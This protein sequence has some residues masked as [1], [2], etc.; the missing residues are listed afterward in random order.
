[1][2]DSDF[3]Q[4]GEL[5]K[6][7]GLKETLTI[8]IGTM[9]GAGI[10]VLPRFAIA[11]AG[12]GAVLAY[13]L[14]GV[15]CMITAAST[16]EL[17]TGMPKSGGAYFFVSRTMGAL[18]G[19]LSGVS[20]WLS[21]VFAVAF[22]LQGFGE[23][24]AMFL[25]L[26]PTILAVLAGAFFTYVNYIGAKETGK[27][28]NII[29]G[30]LLVI[31]TGYIIGGTIYFEVDILTPFL[32]EG[33]GAI[34][35][36]TALIFVSFLGFVQI[37]SVAE[38]VKDPD[39]T[40]PR[41]IIGSVAIVTMIYALVLLVTTGVIP[42]GELV[43]LDAP[44]V[45]VARVFGGAIGAGV[46]TFAALLATAS[47]ANA[48]ILASS[49]ISFALG[50]DAILPKYLNKVHP[51]FM[52]PYRPILLTGI[53]TV[54][55]ILLV[56]VAA[57]S[58]SASVLML[59]NYG[60]INLGVI[61]MRL[62]PPEG[63]EPSYK[64]PGYPVLHIIG[65]VSSFGVIFM[66]GSFAQIVA[67]VL[68]ILS[69]AWY[70]LWAKKRATV[71]GA[72]KNLEWKK[73]FTLKPQL[74]W[75]A[76]EEE[77]VVS[78]TEQ[79]IE[80]NI[81]R[82]LTPLA[83]PKHEKSMLE[84]STKLVQNIGQ[85]SEI[86][87]LNIV[88]IPE[89]TPLDF[90]SEDKDLLH[91]RRKNQQDMLKLAVEFG[92]KKGIIINP[93]VYYSRDKFKTIQNTIKTQDINFLLLGWYGSISAANIYNSF[94]KKLVR[95][96]ECPVGVLKG[97]VAEGSTRRILVPYRGSEHAYYGVEIA[98]RLASNYEDGK[99]SIL[100]IINDSDNIEEEREKA[101]EDIKGLVTPEANL[102]I[103]VI[104]EDKVVDGILAESSKEEYDLMILGAS[105][106]WRVKDM[107][108]GSIP[109]I[110]AERSSIPVLMVRWYNEKIKQIGE[111]VELEET[112]DKE[113]NKF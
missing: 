21:L 79:E 17:A 74:D 81:Y 22:Y 7:L 35:P 101:K 39:Y 45:E 47:S 54:L 27:T 82:V 91:E 31:L 90:I 1:M 32:P 55:L 56:D 73:V 58:D 108:F 18:T 12:P 30:I 109:D 5:V 94:V 46:I 105:K 77:P 72:I 71:T 2:A 89:Q 65:A 34:L 83:N 98:K 111:E 104:V 20:V 57:L 13:I 76:E 8:G 93:Q 24:L 68:V 15:M 92:E 84:L 70:L 62:S 33:P 100:R 85:E 26:N 113:P 40:L 50:K 44:I 49:R 86:N 67:L 38:E 9:I 29:V 52:T 88:E 37:A 6:E 14:A 53:L 43:E 41:S 11:E 96:A 3:S 80:E 28:Q 110:V 107:L 59:L 99:V 51:K 42:Y 66:A 60:L 61:I 36:T 106:K 103:K 63:Y 16:A 87:A 112:E 4:T 48:S 10:F 64:S 78:L 19:T 23:Y 95:S 102:E 75:G 25:P 69:L 97:E